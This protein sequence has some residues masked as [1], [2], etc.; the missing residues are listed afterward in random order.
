M[1]DTVLVVLSCLPVNTR[2]AR[3]MYITTSGLKV[4][5]STVES[6]NLRGGDRG[7]SKEKLDLVW[8]LDGFIHNWWIQW[9]IYPQK[10][11]HAFTFPFLRRESR[12]CMGWKITV[13][14]K[15]TET[16]PRNNR[17]NC[18]GFSSTRS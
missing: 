1:D 2:T 4:V 10:R 3:I 16:Q 13:I 11:S 7:G 17:I 14:S 18:Y 6:H 12:I 15:S 5:L 9:H 8:L